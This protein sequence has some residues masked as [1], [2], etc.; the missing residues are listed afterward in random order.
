MV[1]GDGGCDATTS[2]P[3]EPAIIEVPDSDTP[4]GT[5]SVPDPD[6]ETETETAPDP[7]DGAPAEDIDT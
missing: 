5:V 3:D 6:A 4:G 2:D 1:A 7:E